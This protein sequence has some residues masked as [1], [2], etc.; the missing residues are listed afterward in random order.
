VDGDSDGSAPSATELD[1]LIMI[2]VFIAVILCLVCL[3]L[4]RGVAGFLLVPTGKVGVVTRRWGASHDEPFDVRVNGS[5]GPQAEVLR[6][7]TAHRLPRFIY[8]VSYEPRTYVPPGT[9]GVVV[10]NSGVPP[11]PARSLCRP[12][13][14]DHFQDGRAFLLGGG[15]QGRQPQVLPAATTTST[16]GS[17]RCSRSTPS[18][19]GAT[20]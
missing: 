3:S 13:A 18:G 1:G 14:C 11:S 5:P 2:F 17:S 19:R 8:D 6:S 4:V 20:G 10:A 16:R 9:I 7:N 12:V 15:Q